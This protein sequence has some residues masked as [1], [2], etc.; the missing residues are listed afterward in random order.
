[1]NPRPQTPPVADT[2]PTVEFIANDAQEEPVDQPVGGLPPSIAIAPS[3]SF[4]FVQDDELEAEAQEQ[5]LQ[6]PEAE[7]Q[8]AQPDVEVTEVTETV[9]ELNVNGH[10]VVEDT[11]TI[12]TTEVCT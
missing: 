5:V 9:T 6:E 12:T 11:L 7:V 4:Q 8:E 2:P 1:L 3:S 10:R